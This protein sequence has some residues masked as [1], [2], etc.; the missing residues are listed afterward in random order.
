MAE[1]L[2]GQYR[3]ADDIKFVN[4]VS[5]ELTRYADQVTADS[6]LLF[7][8]LDSYHRLLIHKTVEADFKHLHSFSVGSE[9]R[10]RTAICLQDTMLH[11]GISQ[12]NSSS[13]GRPCRGRGRGKWLEYQNSPP[14]F[15]SPPSQIIKDED[16][17]SNHDIS[18]A[19]L[20]GSRGKARKPEQQIYIPRPRRMQ[21]H[22]Q[23]QYPLDNDD[24]GSS[25]SMGNNTDE[26]GLTPTS[27]DDFYPTL[28]STNPNNNNVNTP[29]MTG[30]KSTPRGTCTARRTRREVEIYI[31]RAK[32]LMQHG[33]PTMD[34]LGEVGGLTNCREHASPLDRLSGEYS[35]NWTV[36]GCQDVNMEVDRQGGKPGLQGLNV[37]ISR[38]PTTH[39]S[40]D[41][42]RRGRRSKQWEYQSQ[43]SSDDSGSSERKVTLAPPSQMEERNRSRPCGRKN[44]NAPQSTLSADNQWS[45]TSDIANKGIYNI[46]RSPGEAGTLRCINERQSNESIARGASQKPTLV[47]ELNKVCDKTTIA[48]SNPTTR[49]QRRSPLS[50]SDTTKVLPGAG[51]A[52]SKSSSPDR[53]AGSK[54][55]KRSISSTPSEATP[56]PASLEL[57]SRQTPADQQCAAIPVDIPREE[58]ADRSNSLSSKSAVDTLASCKR[59]QNAECNDEAVNAAASKDSDDTCLVKN[60]LNRS[61]ETL[62]NKDADSS[63]DT[64]INNDVSSL[65]KSAKKSPSL[66]EQT[67]PSLNGS[68]APCAVEG[69]DEGEDSWD[70]LYDDNGDCL[71]PTVMEEL[72]ANVGKVQIQKTKIDYLEFQPK[73]DLDYK[74]YDHVLEVYK[75]AAELQTKDLIAAFSNFKERGFDIKWVDDTHALAI[76]NSPMAAE[77]ALTLNTPLLKV[78]RMA[79][80]SKKSKQKAKRCTEFLQLY[81][82]RPETSAITARRMVTGALGLT[83][84][85]PKQ[86]RDQEIQQLKEAREKKRQDRKIKQDVWEG[87]IGSKCTVDATTQ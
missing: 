27:P 41:G 45:Y 36:G 44:L 17:R 78:R 23:S 26:R 4:L 35:A 76:F 34:G 49:Q 31:P 43:S 6:V 81:R 11:N 13:G 52:K 82:P 21:Q 20:Q 10:R 84:R 58:E 28:F 56:S 62:S 2:F 42:G 48:N 60:S 80:A 19:S 69:E 5:R 39:R 71:D 7:P 16:T 37:R 3:S 75:F 9:K 54:D 63:T 30:R 77:D 33:G 12:M 51:N 18:P 40:P 38:Q 64:A 29:Q 14:T 25:Y 66:Q 46:Q 79:D 67:P 86:K 24:Y 72:T 65:L 85:I 70:A 61:K 1:Y 87:N 53:P 55:S 15:P 83:P 59:A 32:R 47:N 74:D 57:D 22:H 50:S 73:V 8:P 68:Q